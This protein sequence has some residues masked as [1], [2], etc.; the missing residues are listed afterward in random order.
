MFWIYTSMWFYI[1]I[2]MISTVLFLSWTRPLK[3]SLGRRRAFTVWVYSPS[4]FSHLPLAMSL[5]PNWFLSCLSYLPL[6]RRGEFKPCCQASLVHIPALPQLCE[7]QFTYPQIGAILVPLLE[8][9]WV[10]D[11]ILWFSKCSPQPAASTLYGN[12]LEMWILR[13]HP[14]RPLNQKL[15]GETQ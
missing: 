11:L 3:S 6:W 5:H 8:L 15:G 10:S 12:W 4:P 14:H 1:L 9:W 7:L 13:P 2:S